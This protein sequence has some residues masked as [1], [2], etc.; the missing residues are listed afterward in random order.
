MKKMN[1][2]V[3]IKRK[4]NKKMELYKLNYQDLINNH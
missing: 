4:I 2:L 3:K 1:F